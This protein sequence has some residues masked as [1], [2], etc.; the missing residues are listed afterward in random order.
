MPLRGIRAG[1]AV[2]ADL[3]KFPRVITGNQLFFCHKPGTAVTANP[4]DE[5]W[6]MVKRGYTPVFVS[7][8]GV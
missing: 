2:T 4:G 7:Q 1:M 8:T 6:E 5:K 3:R